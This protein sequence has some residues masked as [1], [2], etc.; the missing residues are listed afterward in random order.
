MSSLITP[1][2][3]IDVGSVAALKRDKRLVFRLDSGRVVA[4]FYYQRPLLLAHPSL[5]SVDDSRTS[6]GGVGDGVAS[7]GSGSG[8][9][10]LSISSPPPPPPMIYALD[11]ACYHHGGPL[12]DG[13]IEEL[14]IEDL[15]EKAPVVLCPW[16]K[17]RI[18]LLHGESFYASLVDVKQRTMVIKSKGVKQRAHVVKAD[19]TDEVRGRVWL[20]DTSV[21]RGILDRST[22]VSE[23]GEEGAAVWLA[24]QRA[25]SESLGGVLE[26]DQ[27]AMQANN[28]GKFSCPGEAPRHHLLLPLGGGPLPLH[29]SRVNVRNTT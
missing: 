5:G 17:Y 11:A 27:Y 13:C 20:C 7:G 25:T 15:G 6:S 2:W 9:A 21:P 8:S 1:P 18:G 10:M 29:S 16:H 12:V 3:W 4:V 14:D 22:L 28:S 19:L 26:S 23:L 24:V